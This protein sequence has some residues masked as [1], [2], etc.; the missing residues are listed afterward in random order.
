MRRMLPE[1]LGP[2]MEARAWTLPT[3]ALERLEVLL[4]L[5]LRYG[6]VMNLSGARTR[7][8]LLPHVLDGLDTAW[9][10]RTEVGEGQ[11]LRW[12]DFGSGGGFPSLVVAAVGDW[13]MMLVEPRQKRVGFL[14]LA[15]RSIGK[16]SI[17]VQT[18]RFDRSTWDQQSASGFLGGVAPGL[19]VVSA[20]AVWS[21]EAWLDIGFHVVDSGGHVVLHLSRA[22]SP[23]KFGARAS[24]ISERGSVA[25][26]HAPPHS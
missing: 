15:L 22:E 5:W 24:V 7:K 21:P 19:R 9:I 20:R 17:G 10:V 12:V 2:W 26:V 25:L 1:E 3:E 11:D 18:A 4:G 13:P 16:I 8:D 23:E 14:E 6:A